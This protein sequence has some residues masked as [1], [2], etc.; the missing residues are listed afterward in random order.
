[1]L[2]QEFAHPL[3]S[4]QVLNAQ[5]QLLRRAGYHPQ[6]TKPPETCNAF[7]L[8]DGRRE[9][10][11]F[12]DDQF[13]VGVHTYSSDELQA[14]CASQP[15]R[16]IPNAVLRPVVQEYLFGSAAF[17]TG[18]NELG[19][20]AELRPVFAAFAVAM[21]PVAPRAGLTLIPASLMRLLEKWNIPPI[22]L[23]EEFDAARFAL[24]ARVQP[25][26]VQQA[27]LQSKS[28]VEHLLA[29]LVE[30]ITPIEPTL[31]QS[32]LSA[33]QRM[34]NEL[35]RLE[36]KTLKAIERRQSSLI[37]RLEQVRQELFPH[38]GLQERTVSLTYWL[39]RFGFALTERLIKILDAQEG[40]HL[41]V[42]I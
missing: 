36:H 4:T 41:F 37:D 26:D 14:C 30:A 16:F 2:A 6:L 25:P 38:H 29:S 15:E 8:Q 40:Q 28:S 3:Q 17:V 42:E 18:P 22:Q 21:P 39:A 23:Y 13:H 19:Y 27:F 33:Q 32:A 12:H 34:R 1:V 20:W 11:T 31:A 7:M 5:A 35:D 10:I 24:L 9:R